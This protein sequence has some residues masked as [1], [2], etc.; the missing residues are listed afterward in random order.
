[1]DKFQWMRG[2]LPECVIFAIGVLLR[3]TMA[4]GWRYRVEWGYDADAHWSYIWHL[5]QHASLPDPAINYVGYHPPLYHIIASGLVKLGA[6]RQEL[7]WLSFAFGVTR[8]AVIWLGLEWYLPNRRARI[9]ALAL[10]AVLPGSIMI[11]GNV[12]NE[13]L[14]GLLAAL[15][16]LI[17]PRAM[18]ATG[19][20][21][22]WLAC[23]L[24]FI[25]GLGMIT[26]TTTL[27][28]MAAFAA[29]IFLG[30]MLSDKPWGFRIK[31]LLPWAAAATACL[32]VSGWFYAHN[33]AR[34]GN[35]FATYYEV[36]GHPAADTPFLARRSLGFVFGWSGAIY[37]TPYFPA[38]L[39]SHPRFFPVALAES[40]TE[41]YNHS[42]SGL[43]PSK[44]REMTINNRPM[45][46]RIL[47]LA[48]GAMMGGT[49][50]LAGTLVAWLICLWNILR[51]KDWERVALLI[52]PALAAL[53][54]LAFAI[55]YPYDSQ[56]V[57]KSVYMQFAAPPL[58]AMFGLAVAW[59]LDHRRWFPAGMLLLSLA[60]VALYSLCCR[61]GLFL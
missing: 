8:L 47:W 52:A 2:R 24:G 59:A 13:S 9:A 53:I 20:N 18:R 40:F 54:A 23:I 43:R 42:F 48:R 17:W 6:T 30:L 46:K 10:L 35:L 50:I 37:Q 15:A 60:A 58:F 44:P 41:Y 14:N 55:K 7:T 57:V 16:M 45:T 61:T 5:L 29:G 22:W 28:L 11:D 34:Y 36:V 25:L 4:A 12:T 3:L 39:L 32:V 1:M 27:A 51:Q 33:V 19:Q 38:G 56:G 26:K 49:I 21:R 31:S